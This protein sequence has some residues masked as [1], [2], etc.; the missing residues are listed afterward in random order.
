MMKRVRVIISGEVQ[1][2]YFRANIKENAIMLD[3]NGYVRN[4]SDGSVEAVFEGEESDIEEMIEFCKEGPRRAKI[5]D[6]DVQEEEY[7]KE[8]DNFEVRF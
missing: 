1:G 3:L 6:V 5:L 2:I 7:K 4:T 8:F